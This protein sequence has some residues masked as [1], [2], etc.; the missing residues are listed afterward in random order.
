MP[1]DF[2]I[3]KDQK[4]FNTPFA[5]HQEKLVRGGKEYFELLIELINTANESIHLQT[6]KFEDDET[7]EAVAEAL[8]DAARRNVQV[9]LLVDGYASQFL[10]EDLSIHCNRQVFTSGFLNRCLEAGISILAQE[11]IIKYL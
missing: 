9:Y 7:G 6:Y 10:P 3:K 4:Q 1:G 2:A 5:S 8:K 11:C